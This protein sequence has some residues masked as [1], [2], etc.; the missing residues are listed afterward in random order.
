MSLECIGILKKL[1][2]DNINTKLAIQCAPVIAGLKI[3]NL[4]VVNNRYVSIMAKMFKGTGIKVFVLCK[5]GEIS[6]VL[7]YRPKMVEAYLNSVDVSLLLAELGYKGLNLHSF[8]YKLR[9]S[10]TNYIKGKKGEFPHELGLALGY[11]P[12]D[13]RGFIANKGKNFEYCGYWKVYGN[14][15]DALEYFKILDMVREHAIRLLG[16][17]KSLLELMEVWNENKNCL[18]VR[19]RQY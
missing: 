8:L 12:H 15:S 16:Q 7:L 13:V 3:S 14:K 9:R 10:Y 1:D 11:P 4:I 6:S 17:S 5:K 2:K 19:N 18:L